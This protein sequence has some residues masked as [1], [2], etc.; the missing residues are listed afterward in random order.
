MDNA[1]LVGVLHGVADLDEQLQPLFGAQ[2]VGIAV[3]GD[4]DALDQF[5]NKVRPSCLSSSGVKDFGDIRMVHYGKSLTLGLET[6][7]NRLGVHAQFDDFESHLAADGLLLL[8][9]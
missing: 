6:G 4:R 2:S 7:D 8:G 1:L 5:H 3:V 9:T